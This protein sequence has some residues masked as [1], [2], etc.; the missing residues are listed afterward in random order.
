MDFTQQKKDVYFFV[1]MLYQVVIVLQKRTSKK[2]RE[3]RRQKDDNFLQSTFL[4]KATLIRFE[5]KTKKRG[6]ELTTILRKSSPSKRTAVLRPR[7]PSSF[8]VLIAQQGWS[9]CER[10][11]GELAGTRACRPVGPERA[12]PCILS[13]E[14][15]GGCY[16]VFFWHQ[17]LLSREVIGSDL[18]F[19]GLFSLLPRKQTVFCLIKEAAWR[20]VGRYL[21]FNK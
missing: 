14:G 6:S 2:D 11:M 18:K 15:N 9:A 13:E 16:F 1:Y 17:S 5:Y 20:P 19:K 4:Q 3:Y 12:L 8:G 10:W 7:S 21:Q